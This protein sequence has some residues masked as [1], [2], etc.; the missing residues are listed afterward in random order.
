MTDPFSLEEKEKSGAAEQP[1]RQSKRE[2]L[3]K[4]GIEEI[5]QYGIAG[6]SMRRI[7][8]T[9]GVSCGAPYKHFEDRKKFIAAIIAYVNDQWHAQQREIVARY[10]GDTRTQIIEVSVSYVEFLVSHPHFRSILMLKDEDFD[11]LYHRQRGEISS[12]T[13]QLI[14]QYCWENHIGSET[15]LRKLYVI[16]ALIFGAA[17]MFDTGE[18]EYNAY[19]LQVVRESIARELDLP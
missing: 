5:N 4:A 14:Q 1:K 12:P 16:R 13:Q 9:C 8:N 19:T 17:L 7:A 2:A 15:K 3:I 6:F 10:E 11:N 18:M